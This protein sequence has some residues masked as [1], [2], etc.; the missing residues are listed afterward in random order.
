MIVEVVGKSKKPY[1]LTDQN[2]K[3]R[4]G[5]SCRL[6]VHVGHYDSDPENGVFGDGELFIELK[7]PD[8]II[9]NVSVGDTLSV[10]LDDKR[11]RIKSAMLQVDNG[12][13]MPI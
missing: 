13:F 8:S 6:S 9:D 10:D 7:A 2:G 5:T 4:K 11:T 1:E 12:G 3:L